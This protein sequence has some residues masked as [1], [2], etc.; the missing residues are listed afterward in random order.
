MTKPRLDLPTQLP[1]SVTRQIYA[2][3]GVT[4]RVVEVVRDYV[5]EVQ[6]RAL[7]VQQDVQKTVSQLDYQP[8][9]LREQ[10]AQAVSAGVQTL[11]LDAQ[12]RRKVVESRV[13]ALQAEA[14]S[15]PSR[16]QRLLDEQVTSAGDTFDELVKRGE[17]LVGRIRRQQSTREAVASA[18]TTT[19]K[20]KTTRTQATKTA[21]KSTA[22]AKR[23][24]KKTPAK[25]SA[26]ATRT[27]AAKTT[28]SGAKAVRDAAKKVGD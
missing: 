20:A 12:A 25:S 19:A 23:T 2:G 26:K 11:G 7:S 21:Q 9:A 18:G 1:E 17:T 10:A 22:A 3:V 13:A 14:L 24:T 15:L 5:A 16:L 8:Q 27:A 6:K 28:T 4:D